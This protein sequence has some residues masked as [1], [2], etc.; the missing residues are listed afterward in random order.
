ML[1]MNK[2]TNIREDNHKFYKELLTQLSRHSDSNSDL[3][4][5]AEKMALQMNNMTEVIEYLLQ[6]EDKNG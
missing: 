2:L 4:K 1:N 6:K 3:L 5:A